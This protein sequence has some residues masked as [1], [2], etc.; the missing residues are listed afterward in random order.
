MEHFIND[1]IVN[2]GATQSPD[3]QR[4]WVAES[5]YSSN[6]QLPEILDHR[7]KLQAVRNQGK[8][9]SCAAQTVACMKE[10]QENKDIGFNKYMSPQFVYNNRINQS[11]EGMYGRDVMKIL[12]NIGCCSEDIYPY[13][14]IEEPDKINKNIFEEAKN[15]KLSLTHKLKQLNV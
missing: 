10:W 15:L 8:Q 11:S 12:S 9:G 4:D 7:K 5:I 3:D 13:R 6:Y 1:V 14:L 2:N